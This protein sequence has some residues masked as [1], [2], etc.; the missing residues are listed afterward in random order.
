MGRLASI[1]GI[2]TDPI[3]VFSFRLG[4]LVKYHT[5]MLTSVISFGLTM[6]KARYESL[7]ADLRAVVD[8]LRG[9]QAAVEMT[10]TTWDDFPEFTKYMTESNIKDAKLDAKSDAELRRQATLYI[11]KHVA[12][13]EGKG[14]PAKQAYARLK[15]L[16]AKYAAA[17]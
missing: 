2:I 12:E 13:L 17:N 7:P 9:M 6:N 14:L 16:S 11:D 15:E 1:D 4:N 10:T 3:G 5:P 8:S